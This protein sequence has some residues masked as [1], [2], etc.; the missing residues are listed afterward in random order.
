MFGTKLNSLDAN[1]FEKR[2]FVI[3]KIYDF[4]KLNLNLNN[5]FLDI[6]QHI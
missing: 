4:K 1:L 5:L 3:K 2:S 6:K